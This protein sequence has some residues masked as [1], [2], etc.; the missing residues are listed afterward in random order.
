MVAKM[1]KENTAN[2]TSEKPDQSLTTLFSRL[3]DDLTEL[4]DAKLQLLKTELKEE[5]TAYASGVSLIVGGAVMGL[6][7][8][9][10]LN[11]G[12][13]FFV[14]MLFGSADLSPA[15]RYGLGFIITALLYLVV[16][17]IIILV[18]KGR[19]AKQRIIPERSAL[20][21]KRDKQWLQGKA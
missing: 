15:V 4:F 20:E 9:A 5:M 7:G 19:L 21:L 18:A 10:V 1:P 6:I 13:A 8:F 17:A 16:G 3:T 11:V 14:S 12:I 2:R